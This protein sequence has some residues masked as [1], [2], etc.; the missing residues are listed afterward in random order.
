MESAR[1]TASWSAFTSAAA[2]FGLGL[3]PS[4]AHTSAS[5]AVNNNFLATVPIFLI[6]CTAMTPEYHN[7]FINMREEGIENALKKL[8]IGLVDSI[9][10]GLAVETG[11][12]VLPYALKVGGMVVKSL[13]EALQMVLRNPASTAEMKQTAIAMQ[14]NLPKVEGM[15]VEKSL[16]IKEPWKSTYWTE[17]AEYTFRGQTNKVYKRDDLFDVKFI[18]KDSKS[19][20]Q[21]MLDGDAPIGCDGRSVNLHHSL[22]TMDGPLVELTQTMHQKYSAIIHINP[23]SVP[24][25]IDRRIFDNWRKEYWIRRAVE[26]GAN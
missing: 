25:G 1:K 17:N 5:N 23:N 13:Q 8:G 6:A 14:A 22:Q 10:L 3:D 9:T 19:N 12:G 7:F 18:G 4:I 11:V 16:S 26:L 21:R 24:S 15:V 2:A 20:M